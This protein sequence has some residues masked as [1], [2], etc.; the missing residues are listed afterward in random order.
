[1]YRKALINLTAIAMAFS[2]A[3]APAVTSFAADE[4]QYD[5]GIILPGEEVEIDGIVITPEE[6]KS[7]EI[8]ENAIIDG[9]VNSQEPDKAAVVVTNGAVASTVIY[10][11]ENGEVSDTRVNV[12]GTIAG[13]DAS[14]GSIVAVNGS[15]N[16][17]GSNGGDDKSAG[18]VNGSHRNIVTQGSGIVTD[19]TAT[20]FVNG[21]VTGLT[22][23]LLINPVPGGEG[24]MILVNGTLGSVNDSITVNSPGVIGIVYHSGNEGNS[25]A[26][27]GDKKAKADAI[28]KSVPDMYAYEYKN[29]AFSV[30]YNV[31]D[32]NE[33]SEIYKE[34]VQKAL[35]D[36]VNYI[37]KVDEGSADFVTITGY[38]QT[39][40]DTYGLITMGTRQALTIA[41]KEGYEIESGST[42]NATLNED[43]TY[44]LKINGYHG[45]ITIKAVMKKISAPVAARPV[46]QEQQTGSES[47]NQPREEEEGTFIFATFTITDSNLP[48]VLGA[49][50]D[51]GELDSAVTPVQVI[52]VKAGALTAKQYKN[53][54]IE[55]VKN[56]PKNAIVRLETSAPS[57]IDKM[58]MEA[59]AQRPDVTLQVVFPLEGELR[60]VTV[61]AGYDVMSLIDENGY[62]GFLY[63][64][65]VFTK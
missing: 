30:T 48:E 38:N 32:N 33:A 55:S 24:G 5:L 21:D 39:M 11:D 7:V 15:V 61:P 28:I 54:F 29:Q 31:G 35:N 42:F 44:T 37:I 63:L 1:M 49:S 62:C 4:A 56:A 17:S 64:N 18:D 9:D 65:A 22:E 2:L 36:K 10:E 19:G 46:S 45:G 53:A 14:E 27:E 26:D 50:R 20:V 41:A 3:C 47:G 58:M 23:G 25:F 57:C 13:I 59:L 8:N 12:N 52:K 40:M 43:G 60:E 16:A 34:Y 51:G 6:G